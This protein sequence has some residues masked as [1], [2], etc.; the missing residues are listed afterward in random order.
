MFISDLSVLIQKIEDRG[1]KPLL[2][3][4]A[5]QSNSIPTSE[6]LVALQASLL[7]TPRATPQLVL[8]FEAAIREEILAFAESG[9]L[10]VVDLARALN[11]RHE[12]FGDLVHFTDAGAA[13]AAQ[14][15]AE[16]I[17]SLP[18]STRTPRN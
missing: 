10:T 16:I 12:A 3:T 8:D 11:G 14:L 18:S 4:H 5:V 7:H 9:K 6:D 2:V 15:I 1:A 13:A 17:V